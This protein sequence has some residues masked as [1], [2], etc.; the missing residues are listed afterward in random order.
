MVNVRVHLVSKKELARRYGKHT[1]AVTFVK[2]GGGIRRIEMA[3]GLSPAQRRKTVYHEVGHIVT[4]RPV[5]KRRIP[6][7]EKRKIASFARWYVR[8]G[9]LKK[10]EEVYEGL[11]VLYQKRK[12]RK[13]P[14]YPFKQALP[15]TYKLLERE[16][17][18]KVKITYVK[19]KR[20][21][22]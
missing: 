13:L 19:N 15:K 17:K 16:R 3:K 2:Q 22:K 10:G 6:L 4:N 14:A 7:S 21:L 9:R 1:K 5:L 18:K 12:Q 20:R 11:A 8:E